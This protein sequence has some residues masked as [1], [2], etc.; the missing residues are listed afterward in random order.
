MC[1]LF[2]LRISLYDAS[3]NSL[4]VSCFGTLGTL[5]TFGTLGFA[6]VFT[7]IG[8]EYCITSFLVS[9]FAF[10]S[11]SISFLNFCSTFDP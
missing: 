9:Y 8:S 2:A 6:C 7:S 4:A 3:K 10:I 11:S 5:G 1:S